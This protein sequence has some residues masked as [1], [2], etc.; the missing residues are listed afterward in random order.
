MP[1][2]ELDDKQF[3]LRVGEACRIGGSAAEIP[4]PGAE[5]SSTEAVLDC[6]DGE[7]VFIRRA[8]DAGEV[9]V[10][11]IR[12]GAE[13]TPLMHGDKIAVGRSELLFGDD[14]SAGNTQFVP[15]YTGGAHRVGG[16]GAG[17]LRLP[18][19]PTAATGGRLVSLVDGREYVVP[20]GGLTIGRDA[21]SDVVVASTEVSRR[22]ASLAP[23]EGGYVL[24]DAS[25]NGLFVNAERVDGARLLG[26]GDVVRVGNEE[27][28]FSAD[29]PAAETA[30][31]PPRD[32]EVGG[33]PPSSEAPSLADTVARPAFAD[34]RPVLATLEII[35]QG[36]LRGRR[37]ELRT[38]LAHVGRGA[39]NDVALA[40][41]SVSQTHAKL[42]KREASWYVVDMASTNGTY[43]AGTRIHGE[44]ALVGA[45]DVRFGGVKM[46]FLPAGAA[47]DAASTRA[48]AGRAPAPV[49]AANRAAARPE[50]SA[51]AS[52]AGPAT[53]RGVSPWLLV[54]GAAAVGAAVFL[55]RQ[56]R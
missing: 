24:R 18:V 4:L 32:T 50:E 56:G 55:F 9:R 41:E 36:V 11:G 43:V 10:N 13:P 49:A 16:D 14:R 52:T 40:D 35:N 7:Q 31:A 51:R 25:T 29:A 2:I 19:R 48:I 33:G 45:T 38:Q 22:H 53:G 34:A 47:E 26:R 42:Q 37:F 5:A 46:R 3:P 30:A 39:H 15:A 54:L 21:G 27:F 44:H 20:D 6:L 12:L 1:Y 28:R 8:S 23:A 17:E